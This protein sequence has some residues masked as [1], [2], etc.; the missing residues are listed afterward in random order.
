MNNVQITA[1][2]SVEKLLTPQ[3]AADYLA[4]SLRHIR[5]LISNRKIKT[6]KVGHLVRIK[7][8]DLVEFVEANTREAI[9]G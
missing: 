2:Q 8:S 9:G 4:T 6:V 7:Q 1:G 3:Q 5:S